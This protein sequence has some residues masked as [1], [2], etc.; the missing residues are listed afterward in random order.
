M[1]LRPAGVHD[2]SL[3][4]PWSLK[5]WKYRHRRLKEM[6][7]AHAATFSAGFQDEKLKKKKK[8]RQGGKS[9]SFYH[10]LQKLREAICRYSVSLPAA[11]LLPFSS[12][13]LGPLNPKGGSSL[14]L[15]GRQFCQGNKFLEGKILAR[16]RGH[17]CPK[18]DGSRKIWNTPQVLSK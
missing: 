8:N 5:M 4:L 17:R 13:F 1:L 15:T 18:M 6:G 10:V 7:A 3:S 16:G 9:E 2:N 11:L 12:R 14:C